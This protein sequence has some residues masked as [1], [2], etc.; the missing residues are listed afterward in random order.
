MS[1]GKKIKSAVVAI[2]VLT[3]VSA[4]QEGGSAPQPRDAGQ[5]FIPLSDV[6]SKNIKGIYVEGAEL[7]RDGGALYR[8]ALEYADYRRKAQKRGAIK[9]GVSAS[10][11]ES[12]P[13]NLLCPQ[14]AARS[15]AKENA[16]AEKKQKRAVDDEGPGAGQIAGWFLEGDVGKLGGVSERMLVRALRLFPKWES[17]RRSHEAVLGYDGCVPPAVAASLGGKAE[18]FFPDPKFIDLAAAFYAKADRCGNG[19]SSDKARY[20]G[21]LLRIWNG[22]CLEA[23][24]YLIK[25]SEQKDGDFVA[26]S[27]YWRHYC[28]KLSGNKMLASAL[29][30]RLQREF[31]LSYHSLIL[32][33]GRGS[34]ITRLLSPSEPLVAFRSALLP[35]LNDPVRAAETLIDSGAHA[36][37]LEMLDVVEDRLGGAEI[38]FRIYVAALS[39]RAGDRIGQFRLLSE[40]FYDEPS[41]ITRGTLEMFYPLRRFDIL[42]NQGH[43]M[44]PFLIAAVIRQESGFSENARSPAGAMGLMQLM[45]ATARRMERVS[46]RELFDAKTN[47]RLGVRYFHGLLMRYKQD[48]ELA[49]AAYNA[50]PERVEDWR[51]RYKTSN[52]MLFLDMIPFKE[53]R[54]YVVLIARNYFWYLNLYA[55]GEQASEDG[56]W[57][58]VIASRRNPVMFTM[59]S[60]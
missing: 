3:G 31:P 34:D 35:E 22:R 53:T 14:A 41:T 38:P 43:K 45:P 21:S 46:R 15:I 13:N 54:D 48:A 40:V 59:F 51:R 19:D 27:L 44:D 5:G 8:Q 26:R 20:R 24:K 39:G 25:L 37:A 23:E 12:I 1:S 16:K 33:R 18:E 36:L 50:G 6:L 2:C 58:R 56:A 4:G 57:E 52:R 17:L 60:R 42:K 55:V 30:G 9:R 11:S 28:A 47:I 49:L 32:S 7:A 29:R 10:C